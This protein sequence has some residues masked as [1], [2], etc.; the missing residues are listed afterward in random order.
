[1]S[2]SN[3]PDCLTSSFASAYKRW[4]A[5]VCIDTY[6]VADLNKPMMLPCPLKERKQVLRR[7]DLREYRTQR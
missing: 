5:F 7:D 4:L 3:V 1:M 6:E 2:E